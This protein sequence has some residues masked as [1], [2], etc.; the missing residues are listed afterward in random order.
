MTNTHKRTHKQTHLLSCT[1]Q[2]PTRSLLDRDISVSSEK[3]HLLADGCLVHL[4]R[5]S[6]ETRRLLLVEDLVDSLKVRL[7]LKQQL[8]MELKL[9]CWV[10]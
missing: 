7:S 9:T 3:L 2:P 10:I 8:S 6:L 5:F 4:N 1:L